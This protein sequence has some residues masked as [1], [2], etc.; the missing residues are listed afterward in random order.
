MKIKDTDLLKGICNEELKEL[1]INWNV[2]YLYI[3]NNNVLFYNS[4]NNLEYAC[5]L[6][7]I[8]D[9]ISN[10]VKGLDEIEIIHT[11]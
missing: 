6:G 10:V 7:S 1:I 2:D 11:I 8:R 3:K 9:Y 4:N 5:M